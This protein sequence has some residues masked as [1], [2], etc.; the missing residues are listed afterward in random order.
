MGAGLILGNTLHLMLRPGLEVIRKFGSLHQFI[1]WSG[2]ILTD[3]GGFQIFSMADLRKLDEEGVCFR[4]PIDG[5]KIFLSPENC[6]EAQTVFGSDI[7]MVLDSCPAAEAPQPE[8]Q[9]AMELSMRWA[10][11]CRQAYRGPGALFGIL[12]GGLCEESRLASLAGLTKT[13]FDGY[14]I[15]GLSTGESAA[16]MYRILSAV[17]PQM[18]VNA[19]RYLM[20]V[21]TPQNL[22]EAM[23]RGVDLFDC[24]MPTRNARN[25][26]LFTHKGV[27]RIRNAEHKS[28][29]IALDDACTC[30]TCANFSRAYLHHLDRCHEMLGQQLNTLHNLHYYMQL[31][32]DFRR[33]LEADTLSEFL[34]RRYTGWQLELPSIVV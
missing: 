22:I 25:G 23:L 21:G 17:L 34:E 32:A 15:G 33:A 4:S 27:V 20:G 14:A 18:P 8:I 28:S 5:K 11:R 29:E 9:A 13:G 16:E 6:M 1:G 24:V 30:Y 10:E 2:A 7:A 3:S 31:M 12:Q 19:P 26:H